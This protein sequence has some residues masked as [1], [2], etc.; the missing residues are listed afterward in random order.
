MR[1]AH[2]F[3]PCGSKL[4]SKDA[5]ERPPLNLGLRRAELDGFRLNAERTSSDPYEQV[6]SI[7]A[8]PAIAPAVAN[9]SMARQLRSQAAA[10]NMPTLARS[11]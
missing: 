10:A 9:S 1:G 8:A 2:G 3:V 6:N 7:R 5:P 11:L 4:R